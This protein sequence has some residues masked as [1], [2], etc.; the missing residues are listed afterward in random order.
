VFTGCTVVIATGSRP[1]IPAIAGL[2]EAGF[3]TNETVFDLTTLPA[4]LAIIGGGP[5]RRE[6]RA[7]KSLSGSFR[8]FDRR[9]SVYRLLK[10][11]LKRRKNVQLFYE[12]IVHS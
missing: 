10:N 9:S 2:A 6:C 8:F 12:L 11:V 4:A 7:C 1:A 3:L 5:G